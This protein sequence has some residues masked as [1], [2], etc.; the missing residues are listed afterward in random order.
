MIRRPPRSTLFPYTTLFRSEGVEGGETD[1]AGLGGALQLGDESGSAF[2]AAS[3]KRDGES[4]AHPRIA[5]P[6]ER[7]GE[8]GRGG[9]VRNGGEMARRLRAAFRIGR[10]QLPQGLLGKSARGGF[11]S[12]RGGRGAGVGGGSVPRPG[13]G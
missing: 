6:C 9:A 5:I 7:R 11:L 4:A 12:P 13:G 10:G 3:D 1:H 8:V 2:A